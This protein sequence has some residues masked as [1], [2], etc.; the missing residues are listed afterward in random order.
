VEASE[1]GVEDGVAAEE[2]GEARDKTRTELM[3]TEVGLI[4][5]SVAGTSAPSLN[6]RTARQKTIRIKLHKWGTNTIHN[7]HDNSHSF[8]MPKY[9]ILYCVVICQNYILKKQE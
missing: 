3:E 5:G 7:S 2:D 9:I 4:G 8:K 1:E 6:N